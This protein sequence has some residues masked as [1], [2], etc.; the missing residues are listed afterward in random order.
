MFAFFQYEN[1]FNYSILIKIWIQVN[2]DFVMFQF[3][4]IQFN[5]DIVELLGFN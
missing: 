1:D 5:S 3:N 2:V 4:S